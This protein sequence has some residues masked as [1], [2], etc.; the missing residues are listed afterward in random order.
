MLVLL[1]VLLSLLVPPS[2]AARGGVATCTDSA[3]CAD[4]LSHLQ[5]NVEAIPDVHSSIKAWLGAALFHLIEKKAA[6]IL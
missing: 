3:T 1:S 5:S 4:A 6:C 2:L